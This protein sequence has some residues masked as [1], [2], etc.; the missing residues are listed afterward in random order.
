[1]RSS[2]DGTF[3]GSAPGTADVI[4]GFYDAG[5]DILYIAIGRERPSGR[6]RTTAFAPGV[7]AE[8][9]M[10]DRLVGIKLLDA[11]RHLPR[12]EL[13]KIA[14]PE[15][16]LTLAQA[17]TLAAGH[18]FVASAATLRRAIRKGLLAGV[19][20]GRNW[21][22]GQWTLEHYLVNHARCHSEREVP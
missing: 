14:E 21:T 20:R 9:D 2:P 22:L 4:T 6:V 5:L 17:E 1:M 19:R 8:F 10:S 13:E 11:T 7:G 18:G 16:V 12:E 15:P 3:H